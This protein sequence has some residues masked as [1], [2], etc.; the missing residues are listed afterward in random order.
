MAQGC[1][2]WCVCGRGTHQLTSTH[3]HSLH[4]LPLA[5]QSLAVH[6]LALINQQGPSGRWWP[7]LLT[8]PTDAPTPAALT[9]QQAAAVQYPPAVAAISEFRGMAAEGYERWQRALAAQQG[10][11]ADTGA[12]AVRSAELFEE[13]LWALHMVQSRCIRMALLGCR[14]LLPGGAFW[15]G[16]RGE[17][18]RERVCAWPR[19]VCGQRVEVHS[20]CQHSIPISPLLCP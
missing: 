11:G 5:A 15:E 20:R 9:Q 4:S 12:G 7:Y 19:G 10:G 18:N 3:P 13:F 8:L 17:E 1:G 16:G 2:I 6:L 14:V